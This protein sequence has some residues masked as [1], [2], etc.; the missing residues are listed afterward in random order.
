[1]DYKDIL[2]KKFKEYATKCSAAQYFKV[3][4]TSSLHKMIHK[5]A[6]SFLEDP[7][8][9]LGIERSN[10]N[11][12]LKYALSIRTPDEAELLKKDDIISNLQFLIKE[13]QEEIK[14]LNKEINKHY[15]NCCF[16]KEYDTVI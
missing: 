4:R 12:Q 15:S 13:Q 5:T 8:V 10:E 6:V 7:E 1:M 9:V 11:E 3:D 16:R 14:Y 2:L